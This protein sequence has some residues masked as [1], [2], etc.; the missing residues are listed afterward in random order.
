MK[1]SKE[2]LA[3]MAGLQA[4]MQAKAAPKPTYG[5]AYRAVRAA[6][7]GVGSLLAD[8]NLVTSKGVQGIGEGVLG[9]LIGALIMGLLGLGVG[10]IAGSPEAGM[11][12]G[13]ILGG[14]LGGTAGI[15][16]GQ[17]S[18]ERRYLRQQGLEPSAP[19][20][21]K[22]LFLRPPIGALLPAPSYLNYRPVDY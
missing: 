7:T 8:P 12:G 11:V 18:A 4:G 1:L 3:F 5:D 21:A 17:L 16:H 10:S 6:P 13:A 22:E 19:I 2:Q 14:G 15:A 20:P 9:G